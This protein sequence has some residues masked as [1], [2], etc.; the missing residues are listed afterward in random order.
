VE[1]RVLVTTNCPDLGQIEPFEATNGGATPLTKVK[2][3][4]D[5]SAEIDTQMVNAN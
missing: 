5:L 1:N 3:I 2:D 4:S